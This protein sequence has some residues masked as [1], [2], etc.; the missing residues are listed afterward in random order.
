MSTARTA[1]KPVEVLEGHVSTMKEAMAQCLVKPGVKPVHRLRTTTRRIEGQLAL[2]ATLPHPPRLTKEK[3]I[4]R[5][6]RRL[7][8]AAGAVRDLDVQ[9]ELIKRVAGPRSKPA[10]KNGGA[11]LQHLFEEE[12]TEAAETLVGVLRRRGDKVVALLETMVSELEV[13]RAVVIEQPQLSQLAVGWFNEHSGDEGAETED[14]DVLHAIRKTAKLS[15]YMAENAPKS[16]RT[17][18]RLAERFEELQEAGGEWH[19]WLIL[20][21]IAAEETKP[22]SELTLVLE[23][24][25]RAA[26]GRYRQE[27]RLDLPQTR[28]ASQT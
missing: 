7:R 6:L 26:L 9:M 27:L 10:M 5:W 11:K 1:A 18:H 23:R 4:R 24:R 13:H 21:Q 20:A 2:L 22:D 28:M 25:C 3:R 14:T 8:R 19:D 17:V 15:R 12:R 16:A